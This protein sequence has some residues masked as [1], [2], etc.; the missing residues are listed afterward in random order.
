MRFGM[1]EY[2]NYPAASRAKS[3]TDS[4]ATIFMFRG[5]ESSACL[6]QAGISHDNGYVR[7]ATRIGTQRQPEEL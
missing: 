5:S 4:A 6:G 3:L 7:L 1:A 2:V